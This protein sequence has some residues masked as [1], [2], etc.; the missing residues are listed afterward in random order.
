MKKH[1]DFIPKKSYV[2]LRSREHARYIAKRWFKFDR[3]DSYLLRYFKTCIWRYSRPKDAEYVGNCYYIVRD[4]NG[5]Y[6]FYV[7]E[8]FVS[9]PV[10]KRYKDY[11]NIYL[12]ALGIE[13]LEDD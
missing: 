4:G 9:S 3:G 10:S 12:L 5:S 8:N 1:P 6:D 11:S 7:D 13:A 2:K